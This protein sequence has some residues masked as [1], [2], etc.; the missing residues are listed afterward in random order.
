M[1]QLNCVYTANAT[2]T[3]PKMPLH[4]HIA[5]TIGRIRNCK[6]RATAGWFV[7]QHIDRLVKQPQPMCWCH[8]SCGADIDCATNARTEPFRSMNF[9]I[10]WTHKLNLRIVVIVL[11]G[12]CHTEKILNE[13]FQNHISFWYNRDTTQLQLLHSRLNMSVGTSSFPYIRGMQKNNF[14]VSYLLY[15]RY[16]T[17]IPIQDTKKNINKPSFLVWW[18]GKIIVPLQ[19]LLVIR[20]N[21]NGYT[22]LRV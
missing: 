17:H 8:R 1:T 4:L 16:L 14:Y 9:E 5:V 19:S 13:Q 6:C 10:V 3:E 20:G 12:D 22:G 18:S 7:R 21:Q 11:G 15:V 2:L